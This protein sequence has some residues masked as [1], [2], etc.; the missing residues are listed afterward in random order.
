MATIGAA[1]PGP[2]HGLQPP[3]LADDEPDDDDPLANACAIHLTELGC[4]YYHRLVLEGPHAGEVWADYRGAD[5]G[6]TCEGAEFLAWY[7]AWIDDALSAWLELIAARA[8]GNGPWTPPALFTRACAAIAP[9]A[10]NLRDQHRDGVIALALGDAAAARRA[11]T[12]H[13]AG[14][15]DSVRGPIG[16]AWSALAAGDPATALA[17][18]ADAR[19]R[20]PTYLGD[21]AAIARVAARAHW[22]AGRADAALD[23]ARA[24]R[25]FHAYADLPHARPGRA[26]AHARADHR[27]RGPDRGGGRRPV[28]VRRRLVESVPAAVGD[29]GRGAHRRADR[30]HR[31]RRPRPATAV[32]RAAREINPR[33]AA[34]IAP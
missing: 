28:P 26:A 32:I 23:E 21:R 9:S 20:A 1:G 10:A 17:A 12:A 16:L 27:T 5:A 24:A 15:P 14:A 33:V 3:A 18:V 2:A 6:V 29:A 30:R 31:R 22:L 11:F 4:G 7:A 34:S 13:A 19:A 25:G 8:V